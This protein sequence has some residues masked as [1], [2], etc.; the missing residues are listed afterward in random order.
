MQAFKKILS[1]QTSWAVGY[2]HFPWVLQ[3]CQDR[4][5]KSVWHFNCV[6]SWHWHRNVLLLT[7]QVLLILYMRKKV[8]SE[9]LAFQQIFQLGKKK[10]WRGLRSIL[11][12]VGRIS[13]CTWWQDSKTEQ[14]PLTSVHDFWEKE[15][16]FTRC[17]GLQ[18]D[19]HTCVCVYVHLKGLFF[20]K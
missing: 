17:R 11:H 4:P 18:M 15:H 12:R 5:T 3:V 16:S 6:K 2:V 14:R 13:H 7:L 1:G 8:R 10:K 9:L 19:A 20:S